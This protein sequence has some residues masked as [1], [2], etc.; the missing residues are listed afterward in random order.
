MTALAGPPALPQLGVI[1]S[2][3]HHTAAVHYFL[4]ECSRRGLNWVRQAIRSEVSHSDAAHLV[5]RLYDIH[6]ACDGEKRAAVVAECA[7]GL[8]LVRMDFGTVRID[9]ASSHQH[10]AALVCDAVADRFRPQRQPDVVDVATWW[11]GRGGYQFAPRRIHAPRWE[12]IERNYPSATRARLREVMSLR[13]PSEGG[14][15]ILWHGEPGTGKSR[16][17]ASLIREW[18]DW[19]E[20]HIVADPDRLFADPGYLIDL[21]SWAHG[22]RVGDHS[23]WKL[24]VAE[25]ADD[26]LRPEARQTSGGAMGRLLNLTDG[27]LGQTANCLVLLTTNEDLGL[28][29]PA[30]TRPGRCLALTE[31]SRFT[32][33][34]ALEWLPEGSRGPGGTVTL[35]ELFEHGGGYL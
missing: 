23:R 24:I 15:L 19:C 18:N 13:R 27:I 9:A 22:P 33:E 10:G 2:E 3:D 11:S 21:T 5:P 32:R 35:A 34:E 31:F 4:A 28:I 26:Y 12:T 29:D 16:A 7:D 17:V 30:L 25:D 14:R 8:V 20:A 1:R 6:M